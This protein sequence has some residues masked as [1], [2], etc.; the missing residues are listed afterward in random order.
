MATPTPEIG[1]ALL[2][3][4]AGDPGADAAQA[5][6]ESA[7]WEVER[8]LQPALALLRLIRPAPGMPALGLL[9]AAAGLPGLGAVGLAK[10]ARSRPG[11]QELPLIV[12]GDLPLDLPRS[13]SVPAGDPIALAGAIAALTIPG[14]AAGA[15]PAEDLLDG[16]IIAMLRELPGL[17]DRA[18]ASF[19]SDLAGHLDDIERAG[20]SGDLA[21]LHRAAHAL[22]GAS[23]SLGARNLHLALARLD[24][25]AVQGQAALAIALIPPLRALAMRSLTALK[26]I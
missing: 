22:K 15:E 25:A 1:T 16:A 26:R 12:V 18:L 10:A 24:Q 19:A 21:Q 5:V 6:C 20:A 8:S 11:A 2:V 17:W 7:G 13:R 4:P 23:G 9:V 3:F 14:P